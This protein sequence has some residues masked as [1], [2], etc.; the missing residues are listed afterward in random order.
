V[1]LNNIHDFTSAFRT[2]MNIKSNLKFR[3]NIIEP[4]S[5]VN[6]TIL[7]VVFFLFNAKFIG[8][9]GIVFDLPQVEY[10]DLYMVNSAVVRLQ[11]NRVFLYNRE[12]DTEKLQAELIRINPE[13]VAIHAGHDVPSKQVTEIIA[14]VKSIGVKQIALA[15]NMVK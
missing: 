13:L 11:N 2:I 1:D 14:I 3:T 7:L 9:P 5:F 10:S 4:I 8:R 15:V 6:V 12:M